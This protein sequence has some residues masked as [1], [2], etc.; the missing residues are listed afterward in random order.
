LRQVATELAR[1]SFAGPIGCILCVVVLVFTTRLLQELPLAT[2]LFIG[3]MTGRVALRAFL[4]LAGRR[5]GSEPPEFRR[6]FVVISS[7]SLS[8]P[9][10]LFTGVVVQNYGFESWNTL[11]LIAFCVACAVSAT[12]VIAPDR[13]LTI[14][15]ELTLLSPI[16]LAGLRAG[17]PR[18]YSMAAATVVFAIYV[19]LHAVRQNEDYWQTVAK[20]EALKARA[21]ELQAA[22][23]AA[24]A[25]STAKSQFLANMSHE[26]RTPMNGVLGMLELVLG[27]NLSSEQRE[28][29]GYARESARSLLGLLNDLLDH[30]KAEAGRLEFEQIDFSIEQLLSFALAPYYKQA[31]EAGVSLSY[32]IAAGVPD[33]VRGDTTRLRQVIVNLVSNAVKF[34]KS[35]SVNVQV[36]LDE[37]AEDS[38]LLHFTVVDTGPG[39]P[40]SKQKAIFDVFSQADSSIAR[41]YGGTGLGLAI[42]RDLVPLMGGRIWL[43][44]RPGH[45]SAF[46]FTARLGKSSGTVQPEVPPARQG[47]IR[48]LHVLVAEDNVINQRVL[49]QMLANAGHSYELASTGTGTIDKHKHGHF[50]AI[51]MDVHMPEMDGL[52]ATRRIRSAE[53][54][55]FAHVPIVGVTAS[56]GKND[57]QACLDSGMDF[58]IAKPIEISELRDIL[59]RVANKKY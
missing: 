53:E 57:L 20:D 10:G 8:L 28:N 19:I 42:C 5:T 35:G 29:L 58:C 21:D 25:A 30:S 18:G 3:V 41:R 55:K 44:S 11:I 59:S 6:W 49:A 52:E 33:F 34:T 51:L 54:S 31:G 16:A 14:G 39:I 15:F 22:R 45:G 38:V 23:A 4:T 26:I 27:S 50:D 12:T 48:P 24:D 40:H 7:Y 32:S 36:Q 2:G 46:H 17:G 9:A 43:R 37:T 1:R 13:G 47:A 56:A